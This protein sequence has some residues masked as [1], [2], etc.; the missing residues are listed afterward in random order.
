MCVVKLNR[1]KD[2]KCWKV[3]CFKNPR[4]ENSL[5]GAQSASHGRRREEGEETGTDSE[6]SQ[7][8]LD[9]LAT[10]TSTIP[11][12]TNSG[13]SQ[14]LGFSRYQCFDIIFWDLVFPCL[15]GYMI[16]YPIALIAYH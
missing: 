3:G 12:H 4:M 9:I 10:A 11:H 16:L 6:S 14:C 15:V 2:I 13:N 1:D 5:R 7:S 8:L